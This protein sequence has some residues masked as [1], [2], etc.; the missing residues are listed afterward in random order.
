MY[1][2]AHWTASFG[3]DYIMVKDGY[4]QYVLDDEGRTL[5]DAPPQAR[6]N[7]PFNEDGIASTKTE[8]ETIYFNLDNEWG[9]DLLEVLE[10]MNRRK[11]ATLLETKQ[12]ET[13]YQRYLRLA[14]S[15]C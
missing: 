5:Y 8:A 15:L 11:L 1:D 12:V 4:Y 13:P 2:I 14:S 9:T 6:L 7:I 3:H 10:S